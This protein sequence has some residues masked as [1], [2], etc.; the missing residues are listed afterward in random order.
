MDLPAGYAFRAPTHADL[1]GVAEVLIADQVDIAEQ[2]V[3]GTD[4]MRDVWSRL[5]FDLANN[6]WVVTDGAG[7]IVAYGQVTLEEPDLVE[8][9]GVVH[10][11]HRGRGIGSSLFDRIEERASGLLAG[12]AS[13]R[14]RSAINAGDLAAAAMLRTRGLQPVRRF[15]HMQIDLAGPV[16]PGSSP[17]GIEIGGIEPTDDLPL[18]HAVLDEA[19]ADDWGH[20]PEPFGRWAEEEASSPRYDPTLWLMAREGGRPV[21]VITASA[22]DDGGSV[23]YVAVLPPYRG[24]GIAQALLHHTFASLAGRGVDRV[25]LNVDAQNPTG[26]TAL[27][28]RVGMRVVNR[29]DLRE[30]SSD[31]PA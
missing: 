20:H 16:E 18:V 22:G 2:P 7:T 15:W 9:W 10:P 4:F 29:W 1:D 23:D 14:F 11:D 27:Y 19:F 8:S 30:R 12:V 13:P 31:A 3:L 6:V 17:E 21:G 28:E 26:A 24:R 5:D 25:M